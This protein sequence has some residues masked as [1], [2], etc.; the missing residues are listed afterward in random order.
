MRST[1]IAV[2]SWEPLVSDAVA[3]WLDALPG[4]IV[5][6]TACTREDL[7]LLCS[8][9]P[10]DVVVGQLSPELVPGFPLVALSPACGLASLRASLEHVPL[11]SLRRVAPGALTD[12]EMEVLAHVCS[13]LSAVSVASVLRL[14][15]HT[16][17]NY[18]RRIFAKL[19]V[20]SRAQA[21]AVV[22]RLGLVRVSCR[23]AVLHDNVPTLTHRENDILASIARG[24]S[25]RQTASALGIAVKTVESEQRQLFFKLRV[26]N[27]AQA[28]S[29]AQRLGLLT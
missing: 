9:R 25:V 28:L 17:V 15:P 8:L 18:K 24:E 29:E 4:W 22:T 27:R 23:D 19:G 3:N 21:A 7:L 6:G 10:P 12:R 26:H 13:G 11:T 14:S 5:V 1:R 20:Q 16:V 2:H